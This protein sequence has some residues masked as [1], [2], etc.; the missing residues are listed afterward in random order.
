[1]ELARA[2]H[3]DECQGE[4]ISTLDN[5]VMVGDE[6]NLLPIIRSVLVGD[7]LSYQVFYVY[8]IW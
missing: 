8:G 4:E 3:K 6:A 7:H 1:M 5:F 2:G